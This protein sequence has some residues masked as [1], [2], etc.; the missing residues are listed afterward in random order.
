MSG[1][2]ATSRERIVMSREEEAEALINEAF[3]ENVT[4]TLS[5]H[6][7]DYLSSITDGDGDGTQQRTV[8]SW[9][10]SLETALV[11]LAEYMSTLHVGEEEDDAGMLHAYLRDRERV[12]K[13][14][15][16]SIS[17]LSPDLYPY[18]N[19][20]A[21]FG[22]S[23]KV[24]V[25]ADLDRL[26][27][28]EIARSAPEERPP[29]ENVRDLG[30]F[31]KEA[32][33]IF[34]APVINSFESLAQFPKELAGYALTECVRFVEATSEF[35]RV[36]E[37]FPGDDFRSLLHGI[38]VRIL[39]SVSSD[40]DLAHL[41]PPS[42]D[43]KR[44]AALKKNPAKPQG[45]GPDL[46][47]KPKVASDV[48]L[49]HESVYDA[50]VLKAPD[51]LAA[52][53]YLAALHS[54]ERRGIFCSGLFYSVCFVL[55]QCVSGHALQLETAAYSRRAIASAVRRA[56]TADFDSAYADDDRD[57]GESV[58][59]EVS[60]PGEGVARLMVTSGGFFGDSS[61]FGRELRELVMGGHSEDVMVFANEVLERNRAS[62]AVR[63]LVTSLLDL[64]DRMRERETSGRAA[65]PPPPRG[66]NE[67]VW[68]GEQMATALQDAEVDRYALARAYGQLYPEYVTDHMLQSIGPASFQPDPD[69]SVL[70]LLANLFASTEVERY[71]KELYAT[72]A[73][74]VF[75]VLTDDQ[76]SLKT[77]KNT[78]SPF[79]RDN[80]LSKIAALGSVA[81]DENRTAH[82]AVRL[83]E[84]DS[85]VNQG[86]R[87]VSEAESVG[88]TSEG[89]ELLRSLAEN[90]VALRSNEKALGL[91]MNPPS[92]R[93]SDLSNEIVAL[94][95]GLLFV[96]D[97]CTML[98]PAS[99]APP[100]KPS[101][102][103]EPGT[104]WM[105]SVNT[106]AL[107]TVVK[108][109][110]ARINM[111]I[112]SIAGAIPEL[113][114]DLIAY[115]G[116]YTRD[117]QNSPVYRYVLSNFSRVYLS[118]SPVPDGTKWK[119]IVIAA[120]AEKGRTLVKGQLGL[121]AV[122]AVSLAVDIKL[123]SPSKKRAL[124]SNIAFLC[125]F[126]TL[127][128]AFDTSWLCNPH[129]FYVLDTIDR[130]GA[131][132]GPLRVAKLSPKK[133]ANSISGNSAMRRTVLGISQE[134]RSGF[135]EHNKWLDGL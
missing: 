100:L 30:T 120:V 104:V 44:L 125:L 74:N 53:R 33:L 18:R 69:A 123:H 9:M 82:I 115:E 8:E 134:N 72:T 89:A 106:D 7:R 129:F 127:K 55:L 40:P 84:L 31:R 2:S 96:A 99:N 10:K 43:L 38:N 66:E 119:E 49:A 73:K 50:L 46:Y 37:D 45:Y 113:R 58:T 51:L 116:M 14:A 42:L 93:G 109:I 128:A 52:V 12:L 86:I 27:H 77:W 68:N 11:Q 48:L 32:A 36:Q 90:W 85:N 80:T 35:Y 83:P 81:V 133:E 76:A 87:W 110:L 39:S 91:V 21:R 23:R 88:R 41:K 105:L 98:T 56:G 130:R 3:K 126:T 17:T 59:S 60:R 112:S 111:L 19:A 63:K 101:D 5:A 95:S 22:M 15:L 65:P 94:A 26:L 64:V 25:S 92:E 67:E 20:V 4:K 114:P 24:G 29:S 131:D 13:A 108:Y 107:H 135:E 79:G 132:T 54:F 70:D 34:C 117:C 75:G 118:K 71:V 121:A 78:F 124:A 1:E 122:A 6:I 62:P 103:N 47:S 57:D 61:A 97:S 28:E 102:S 16:D